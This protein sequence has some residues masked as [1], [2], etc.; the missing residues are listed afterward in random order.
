MNPARVEARR[1]EE[2]D[3]WALL[4]GE[5]EITA[6]SIERLTGLGRGRAR[7]LLRAWEGRGRIHELRMDGHAR[8]YAHGARSAGLEDLRSRL[9][10]EGSADPRRNMWRA[11]QL[12]GSF[13][14]LDLVAVSNLPEAPVTERSAQAFCQSLLK[15]EYL[16]VMQKARPGHRPARYV[17]ARRTGPIPPVERRVAALWDANLG[18]LT[19]VAGIGVTS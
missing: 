15:G 4:A 8:V 2:A 11:M 6:R 7:E 16:R 18:A 17:L 12:M 19:Y 14:P 1:A 13:S 3:A 5:A 9:S 10:G